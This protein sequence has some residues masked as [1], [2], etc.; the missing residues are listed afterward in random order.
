MLK[1]MKYEFRKTL[2][3]KMILL[4]IT[5]LLELIFLAGVFLEN[6]EAFGIGIGGLLLC[7]IVGI[8]Y[9]GIE[10][11]TV[12]HKDLNTKQSYMLFMTPN[13]S[14]KILGAKVLENGLSILMAGMFFAA[15]AALDASVA[16]LY[17]GGLE[18]FL[19]LLEQIAI[20][21]E[22]NVH[23]EGK[24]LFMAF[25]VT[26]VSWMMT[27]VTADL[28]IVLS[29]TVL[30]GKKFSGF[31]GFVIFCIITTLISNLLSAL[32]ELS[33]L[34]ANFALIIGLTLVMVVIMYSITAWIMDRKLSV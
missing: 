34:Y 23:I 26:L 29:A 20:S 7:A 1:L 2:F 33:N 25:L 12:F 6:E 16:I 30:A 19:M 15:L 32:P 8:M 27:I 17:I 5:G 18:E 10:S 14:F 21:F 31:V 28:A 13:S 4:A 3:S 9:I 22:L 24:A 11:I